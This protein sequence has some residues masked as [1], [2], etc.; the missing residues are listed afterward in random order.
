MVEDSTV[1]LGKR[2]TP[3]GGVL[4]FLK[5]KKVKPPC[6]PVSQILDTLLPV[7]LATEIVAAFKENY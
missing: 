2:S 6:S 4:T 7:T 5:A 1:T 3:V